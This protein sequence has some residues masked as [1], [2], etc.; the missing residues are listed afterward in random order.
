MPSL[1]QRSIA[2]SS[3]RNS[4]EVWTTLLK[5]RHTPRAGAPWFGSATCGALDQK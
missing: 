1:A 2:S 3:A 5:F 4:I